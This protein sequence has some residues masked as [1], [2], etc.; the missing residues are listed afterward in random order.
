MR[1]RKIYLAA[2]LAA[3]MAL[4]TPVMACAAGEANAPGQQGGSTADTGDE[5]WVINGD[6]TITDDSSTS[7]DTD[8]PA[9]NEDGEDSLKTLGAY[10]GQTVTVNGDVTSST[11]VNSAIDDKNNPYSPVAVEAIDNGSSLVVNGDVSSANTGAIWADGGTVSV[12]GNVTSNAA[13]EP[14]VSTGENGGTVNVGGNVTAASG[15]GIISVDGNSTIKVDGS[16]SSNGSDSPAILTN[17]SSSIMVGK[18]VSGDTGIV[19]QIDDSNG[20]GKV[21]VLGTV[22]STVG[23]HSVIT[24]ETDKTDK[25]E[26]VAALPTIIVGSLEG[27]AESPE[28]YLWISSEESMQQGSA[29]EVYEAVFSRLLYYIAQDKFANASLSVSGANDYADGGWT[30]NEGKRL[31]VTITAADGYEVSDVSGTDVVKNADGT[32]TV[33]VQRGK[34]IDLNALISAIAKA[35]KDVPGDGAAAVV[36]IPSYTVAQKAFQAAIIA[37]QQTLPAGG[38]L[39]LEMKDCISFNKK[40]FEALSKRNDVDIEV[41][42]MW[43][44]KKY[45]VVIPAGY[46]ILSLLDKNGYCGC[47]YLNSIFGSTEIAN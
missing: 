41:V 4:Q 38:T 32:Y 11:T 16:V 39:T 2:I 46:D 30:S 5:T 44:G 37:Q 29:D 1:K 10:G 43:Q 36:V 15:V 17:G 8:N 21:E 40:T 31:T 25:E 14:V 28:D 6:V 12:T 45:R 9:L 24:I 20:R 7:T 26:L 34:G 33:L 42:Y 22:K 3:V 13:E 35:Q 18:E 23:N 19:I 47:L 27:A